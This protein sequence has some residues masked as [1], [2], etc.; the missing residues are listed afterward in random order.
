MDPRNVLDQGEK[1]WRLDEHLSSD[2]RYNPFRLVN[3][4]SLICLCFLLPYEISFVIKHAI[5][6]VL[7]VVK[8]MIYL[9]S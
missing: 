2:S 1:V 9:Q 3:M 6:L 4:T 7:L 8:H 5:G